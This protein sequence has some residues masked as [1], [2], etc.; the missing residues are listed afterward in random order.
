MSVKH[1]TIEVSL[2]AKDAVPGVDELLRRVFLSAG[3]DPVD[4][5]QYADEKGVCVSVYLSSMKK[6][7]KIR[8]DIR[9]L[10]LRGVRL[11]AKSLS[12]EDWQDLWKKEIMPFPLTK[13]FDVVPVWHREKYKPGHR[14]PILIDT[15]FVFGTGLHETTRFVAEL[16]EEKR[17]R[18][19]EFF[20]IGTG[21]G[22]LAVVALKCGAVRAD[23]VD[24]VPESIRLARYNAGINKEKISW[25]RAGD[26]GK[27][28][29]PRK[30]DFVTANL[31]THDLIRMRRKIVARVKK[32]GYL[33]VSGISLA[34]AG[35]V[36]RH[37]RKS[38]LRCLKI[39]KGE[40]WATFL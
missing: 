39:K 21:T 31:I 4:I 22:L 18:F 30:Y 36:R 10:F 6:A 19:N 13:Q 14:T 11:T 3:C 35:L 20:D 28:K 9:D 40:K 7:E 26:F 38:P 25:A 37:F 34:N 1:K 24:I 27:M 16:I 8:Q 5:T 12:Q 15:S 2:A 29:V 23:A 17:G 32:G 33:A